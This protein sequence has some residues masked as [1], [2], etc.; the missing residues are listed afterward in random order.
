MSKKRKIIN[1]IEKTT[2]PLKDL[3]K[4]KRGIS[5]EGF[6]GRGEN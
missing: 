2:I 6:Y 5:L 4:L 3:H 1:T